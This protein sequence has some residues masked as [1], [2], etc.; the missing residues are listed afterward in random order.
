MENEAEAP[1]EKSR[2]EEIAREIITPVMDKVSEVAFDFIHQYKRDSETP[3]NIPV[4]VKDGVLEKLDEVVEYL[5]DRASY[6]AGASLIGYALGQDGAAPGR[7][8][9]GMAEVAG[10]L[11]DL[12]TA[13]N[14]QIKAECAG[15]REYE[16]QKRTAKKLGFGGF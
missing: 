12:I 16:E 6:Y 4:G 7:R 5:K 10:A 9:K 14:E 15:M 3:I 2:F 8:Y 1:E 11:R 13:R